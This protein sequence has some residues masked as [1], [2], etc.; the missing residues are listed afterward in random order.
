[1]L[2]SLA[3]AA[4]LVA[5]PAQQDPPPAPPTQAGEP[6]IRLEDVVS[7]ARTLREATESFVDEVAAPVRRR[8]IGRWHGGV[9]VG[10][11]NLSTEAAQYI[12]DR[13]SDVARDLDLRPG[14]PGC[15]PRILVVAATDGDAFT[16]AFVDMRPRLFRTGIGGMD[17]GRAAFEKFLNADAPVRWWTVSLPVDEDTG[18]VA[19]RTSDQPPVTQ[20][21]G[22][23]RISSQYRQDLARTFVIVDVDRLEGV[24]L[25]QLADYIAFVSLAEVDPEADTS[26][27]DTILNLFDNPQAADGLTGWDTAYLRGLYESDWRRTHQNSQ[28]R[29]IAHTI[30]NEYRALDRSGEDA[31]E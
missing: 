31:P 8:G 4:A 25:A 27:Y 28:V 17:R 1:M 3:F 9:C 21:R 14:A 12:V 30:T 29:A 15:E 10:V 23:S 22:V 2:T 24:S 7:N 26:S 19:V 13:V 20:V 5:G 16:R 18:A 6:T 11:A